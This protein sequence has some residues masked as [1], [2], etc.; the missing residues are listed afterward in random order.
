MST[1]T[2]GALMQQPPTDPAPPPASLRAPPRARPLRHQVATSDLDVAGR[3]R[4][5][6]IAAIGNATHG[7]RACGRHEVY[8]RLQ[9]RMKVDGPRPLETLFGDLVLLANLGRPESALRAI[10]AEVGAVIDDLYPAAVRRDLDA[11]DLAEC[12]LEAAENLVTLRRR[13]QGDTPALLREAAVID[14]AEAV[15][16]L[17]RA[18]VLETTARRLECAAP[19]AAEKSQAGRAPSARTAGLQ[20]GAPRA[21]KVAAHAHPCHV[22][23]EE[24]R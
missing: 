7:L 10:E 11:L 18:R 4:A 16:Q 13:M 1:C 2:P 22:L 21:R 15:L 5:A 9:G 3:A 8:W 14:R 12:E 6:M 17:E 24:V 23:V 19:A 20:P